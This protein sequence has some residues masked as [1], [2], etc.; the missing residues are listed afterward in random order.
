MTQNGSKDP[1][2]EKNNFLF[3]L[4]RKKVRRTILGALTAFW[5]FFDMGVSGK[6]I[7]FVISLF[8]QFDILVQTILKKGTVCVCVFREGG[9]G[10]NK[11]LVRWLNTR[12]CTSLAWDVLACNPE[13]PSAFDPGKNTMT[14]GQQLL[15]NVAL[16]FLEHYE[17]YTWKCSNSEIPTRRVGRKG[18]LG[19]PP[20]AVLH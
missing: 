1:Q 12:L 6:E 17:F 19:T 14:I 11:T 7:M 2:V 16:G 5:I 20:L 9:G 10:G 8:N 13:K 18:L 15:P 3:I 4:N